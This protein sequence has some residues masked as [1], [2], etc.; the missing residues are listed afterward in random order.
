VL[1]RA[2]TK[3]SAANKRNKNAVNEKTVQESEE[4]EHKQDHTRILLVI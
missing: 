4:R 1:C 3:E 2:V